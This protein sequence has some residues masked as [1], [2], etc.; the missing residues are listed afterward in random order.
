M[1]AGRCRWWNCC[2]RREAQT[3]GDYVL[4]V[5]VKD[6]GGGVG[7]LV[8][9]IDG[10]EVQGRQ[11]DIPSGDTVSRSFP[12]ASGRRVITVAAANTRGVES[13]PVQVV[14]ESKP[15][16]E[17][18]ALH[19]LAVGVT[20]YYDASL[21][22]KH[23]ARDAQVLASELEKRG[24]NL[25]PRGV[26]VKVLSDKDATVS[27]IG[28]A[29]SELEKAFK[30]E[31]TFVLFIAGHGQTS[32]DGKYYFL[33][34]EIEYD[35]EAALTRQGLGE[36]RL[37][38]MMARMPAQSLTVLDT[39]RSGTAISLAARASED[40]G[41]ISRLA[42][43]SKRAIITAST[44]Q[45]MAMEGYGD[46]GVLTYAVLQGLRDGDY[47]KDKRVSVDEL[48]LYIRNVV[49]KITEEKFKFRQIPMRE[50]NDA[51]FP[52]ASPDTK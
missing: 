20:D 51:T 33:P 42:R 5:R 25:F 47:D 17:R 23:G 45:G 28:T 13:K 26:H 35:S 4:T 3:E 37:S 21:R 49:P 29:F 39:C 48:A 43:I 34:W 40:R 24:K 9:R 10:V 52:L 22:L 16:M 38:E 30:P 6:Q 27:R 44:P 50:L 15:A 11:S 19:V 14:V 46:H 2:P 18:P 7:R 12:L 8:Y 36:D 31:D 41:A 32:Q 1:P